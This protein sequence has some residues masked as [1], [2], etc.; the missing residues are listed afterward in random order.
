MGFLAPAPDVPEI[1]TVATLTGPAELTGPQGERLERWPRARTFVLEDQT[2]VVIHQ[3][4]RGAALERSEYPVAA[5][6]Y[7]SRT[8]RLSVV[9]GGDDPALAGAALTV[10]NHCGCGWGAI[11]NAGPTDGPYRL[12]KVRTPEWHTV[13]R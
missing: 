11:T 9:I 12:T 13:T 6:D 3:A 5:S 7:N 4:G 10:T 8:K 1:R 2:L